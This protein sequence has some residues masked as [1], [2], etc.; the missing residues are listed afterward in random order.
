MNFPTA[1]GVGRWD[2]LTF[3]ATDFGNN[4]S[5]DSG[6]SSEGNT[7][8]GGVHSSVG[9]VLFVSRLVLTTSSEIKYKNFKNK[10]SRSFLKV[11]EMVRPVAQN[12]Q[13]FF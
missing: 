6:C 4:A 10:S 1:F 8:S 2:I 12:S 9:T 5:I 11:L 13:S 3:G 7:W